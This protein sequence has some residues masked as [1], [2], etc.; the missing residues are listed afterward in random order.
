VEVLV[1]VYHQDL[2]LPPGKPPKIE[3]PPPHVRPINHIDF[4]KYQDTL[5]FHESRRASRQLLVSQGNFTDKSVVER[6]LIPFI[7]DRDQVLYSRFLQ[8]KPP[9]PL[10]TLSDNTATTETSIFDPKKIIL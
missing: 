2:P 9:K 8:K 4:L 7:S 1:K 10:Q 5:Y 6:A 3:R